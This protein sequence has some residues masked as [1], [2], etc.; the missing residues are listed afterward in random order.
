MFG[1]LMPR[2]GEF[3]DLFNA[4]AEE[5]VKGGEALVAL[6]AALIKAPEEAAK[7]AEAIDVYESKADKITHDTMALIHKTFVTPFD[8]DEIH[9]LISGLD[10]ILDLIQD[11]AECLNLYD[12]HRVTAEASQL[13][14]LSL[15][16]C[17]R[18]RSAVTLL[19]SMDNS[20]A[21]LKICQ[22]IDQLESDA[23]RVMRTAMSRLFRDEA[24]VRQV[25]KLKAVYE[26]L[27]TVT[28]RCEDV[29]NIIEGIV[30][31]NA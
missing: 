17:E 4:H 13:A 12:I 8:R 11:V 29:A 1:K 7:H 20:E 9:S 10:D 16:C 30:L 3:F 27:E 5:I 31:E 23:D 21:I 24:D 22:E 26:L 18:V 19:R 6:M 14:D 15:A 28:D 2:E 25:I